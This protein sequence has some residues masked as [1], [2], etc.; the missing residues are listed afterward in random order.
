MIQVKL[1]TKKILDREI[2]KEKF[3]ELDKYLSKLPEAFRVWPEALF[4][5]FKLSGHAEQAEYGH[6]IICAAATNQ[7]ATCISSLT[8][9]A[10]I[11]ELNYQLEAGS[12]SCQLIDVKL[13]STQELLFSQ[14]IFAEF[15][16]GLEQIACSE[17]AQ[18]GSYIEVI[19][20][21]LE[22]KR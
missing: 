6:D 4:T 5:G 14:M 18:N 17:Q 3:N 20:P 16:L 9:L 7:A 1:E 12:I 15:Y 22:R 11:T 21:K 19:A 8:D 13:L 10:N 2:S